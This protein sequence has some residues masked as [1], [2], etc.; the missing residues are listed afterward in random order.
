VPYGDVEENGPYFLAFSAD[1][2]RY[3]HMLSRMFGTSG[4]GVHDRLMDFTRPVSGGLHFA[5][6]L[7]ALSKLVGLTAK[8][9]AARTALT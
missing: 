4:D 1:P 2:P 6:S 7:N 8:K 3:R 5:P 9:F